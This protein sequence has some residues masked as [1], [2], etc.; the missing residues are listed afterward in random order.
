MVLCERWIVT[1][2]EGIRWSTWYQTPQEAEK[3]RRRLEQL[4][5]LPE[6]E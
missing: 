5:E 4:G 3:E 2:E 6:P 1:D